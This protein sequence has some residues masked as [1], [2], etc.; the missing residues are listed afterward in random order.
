[1][2]VKLIILDFDGTLGDTREII[3]RTNQE[4]MRRKGFPV[5]PEKAIMDT[6]GLPLEEC[7]MAM[8]PD[9]PRQELPGWVATYREIFESLKGS[10]S[11]SLFPGVRDTMEELA[12]K[13]YRLSVASSRGR[14]SLR[15]FLRDMG[16][17]DHICYVLGAEDVTLAKPN[18]DPVLKTLRDLHLDASEALVV[19]DMPV[20]ILMGLRA[21]TRTCGVSY[22]NSS[23]EAL[24][25]SGADYVI[26]QFADL[27]ELIR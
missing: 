6:V 24:L 11:P 17:A 5:L 1:M 26:D 16:I 3:I 25:A 15:F 27:P 7:F 8:Y 4:L 12:G 10:M 2:P 13:G 18:P 21:G 20:D 23:R 19:G 22:G 14:E 9:F